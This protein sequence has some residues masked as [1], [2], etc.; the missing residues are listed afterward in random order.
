MCAPEFKLQNTKIFSLTKPILKQ[1]KNFVKV[2]TRY[3]CQETPIDVKNC[4]KNALN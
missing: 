2:N 4:V 3:T 1:I